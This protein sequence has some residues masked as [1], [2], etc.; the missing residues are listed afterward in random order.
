MKPMLKKLELSLFHYDNSGAK[1]SGPHK[2]L[3]IS[4]A[5]CGMKKWDGEGW[6]DRPVTGN[7]SN[8][9]GEISS[10]FYGNVSGI[11][12]KVSAQLYGDV[13]AL[14]G[15]VSGISGDA[16]GVKGSPTDVTGNLDD[17][18]ISYIDRKRGA[19]ISALIMKEA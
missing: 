9:Y 5:K 13:S 14:R 1:I 10:G 15:D 19:H 2:R 18:E 17:C 7:C 8:I 4:I 16:T 6:P 11:S 12:G 3:K